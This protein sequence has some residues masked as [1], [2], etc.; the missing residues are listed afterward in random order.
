MIRDRFLPLNYEQ[1]L[2]EQLHHCVHG[3]QIVH[4]YTAEY[5]RLQARTNLV[6][7]PYYQMVRYVN[8]LRK[9]I[10]DRVEMYPLQH[11]TDAIS[12][13]SKAE[14]QLTNAPQRSYPQR[15]QRTY[16]PQPSQFSSEHKQDPSSSISNY[17]P[18]ATKDYN[19]PDIT[20]QPKPAFVPLRTNPRRPQENQST[21]PYAKPF[22]IRCYRCGTPGHRS[23]ECT[24]RPRAV[25]LLD[26]F[27]NTV[28]HE[29][30]QQDQWDESDDIEEIVMPD[31]GN[32]VLCM[33]PTDTNENRLYM[34]RNIPTPNPICS[35][36]ITFI[37]QKLLLAPKKKEEPQ[38]QTIFKTRCTIQGRVC[39]V[40]I[41]SGS[42]ENIV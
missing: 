29:E 38:C 30:F 22:P 41:D 35:D 23:N 36:D 14:K 13:A 7:A 18:P 31:E 3:N 20:S 26:E 1:L 28:P 2:W 32:R 6:E 9:D 17:N 11:I 15:P 39:D 40:I 16:T 8:G 21:N 33:F 27:P 4:Q 34:V 24:Q 19:K 37:L 42:S 12:L 5:Q 25:G 10:K